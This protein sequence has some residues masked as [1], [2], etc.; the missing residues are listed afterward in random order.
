MKRASYLVAVAL[1]G[2]A[3]AQ[4]V[5]QVPWM[6]GE[7]LVQLTTAAPGAKGNFDLTREQY[8]D[9]ERVRNYVEGVHDA[10]EGKDWC[11]SEKYHPG[12]SALQEDAVW[13]LRKLPPDQLKRN[14]ADL[15]VGIW[16]KKWPCG[17]KR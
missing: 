4:P 9:H 13:G 3:L 6:T 14:A 5:S 16:R 17:G 12:P 8:R 10:T 1:S 15:I 2:T 7:R 11:Y